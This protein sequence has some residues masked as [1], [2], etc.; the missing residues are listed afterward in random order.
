LTTISVLKN[1]YFSLTHWTAKPIL[2]Y[3]LG[4]I[5]VYIQT[6]FGLEKYKDLFGPAGST[7]GLRKYRILGVSI[8]DL[9]V[10]M[11]L[12]IP[13]SWYLGYSYWI[14]LVILLIFGIFIHRI[15]GARTAVDKFL[16]P[17]AK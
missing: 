3:N 16:F 7:T 11:L 17:N 15:F 2:I 14:T 1:Y 9:S 12:C 13:I 10:V 5:Y 8:L 4:I 6:M